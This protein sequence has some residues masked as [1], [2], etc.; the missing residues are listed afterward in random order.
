MVRTNRKPT[1][2][3]FLKESKKSIGKKEI[4]DAIVQEGMRA[5]KI[6][7]VVPQEPQTR[8][9]KRKC[10]QCKDIFECEFVDTTKICSECE[11]KNSQS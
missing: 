11:F 5:K 3:K 7:K 10:T 8:F 6:K 9:K 1:P 4:A 2:K